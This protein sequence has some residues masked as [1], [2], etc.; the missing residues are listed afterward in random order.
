MKIKE[1]KQM[2]KSIIEEGTEF[3]YMLLSRLQHDNDYYLDMGNR[4]PKI[5]W[6]GNEKDQI[7]KMKEL[8]NK[9]EEKPEWISMEDIENYE[10]HMVDAEFV[11][12]SE[13]YSNKTLGTLMLTKDDFKSDSLNLWSYILDL[14]YEHEYISHE[15]RD[16]VDMVEVAVLAP[17]N[18]AEISYR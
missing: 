10:K 1:L 5:L 11:E 3:N 8:Y 16:K 4:N 7:A 2:V 6:A 18:T 12:E 17:K 13:G 14:L 9:I 15:D